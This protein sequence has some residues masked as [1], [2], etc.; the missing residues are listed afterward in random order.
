MGFTTNLFSECLTNLS[1]TNN[2]EHRKNAVMKITLSKR[3]LAVVLVIALILSA[4]N[5]YLIV[6]MQQG[7]KADDSTFNYVILQDG[8]LV[9]A[10]NQQSSLIDFSSD[11]AT[12][13][14]NQAINQGNHVYVKSGNY[15][16]NSDVEILNKNDARLI[17]DGANINANG[18]IIIIKGDNYTLSQYNEVSGFNIV[19]GTI[20]VENSFA[21]TISDMTFQNCKTAI[22]LTNSETW[23][24]GTK[25][26]NIHF[27][28]CAEAIAFRTPTGNATGS[29]ASTQ[30][31]RAFFNQEDN[32]VGINV[33]KD[34]E[35]SDSQI[36]NSRM[37]LGET[38]RTNQTGLFVDGSMFQTL[39]SSVV[40]ESFAD[41]PQNMYA[42]SVG[43]NA[44]PAPTIDEGVSFL[45]NW[46]ARVH[47]PYSKWLGGIG[48]VFRRT[49]NIPL[50]TDNEF[51]ETVNIQ[52]RPLT[53][54]SFKPKIDV[55]GIAAGE[56]VT[57]RVRLEF[58]DNVISQSVEKLFFNTTSTW[59]TD[60]DML[61][62]FPSQDVV[63][64]VLVDAKSSSASTSASVTVGI[65]GVAT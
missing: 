51:G 21:T 18:H 59:L 20:K 40:F 34:A 7:Y 25:I 30:I 5:T 4:V 22:E 36:S 53:I 14:I 33:E 56:T 47:N 16:L 44:N 11:S 49:E 15:T 6:T 55:Q 23:T 32:S 43:A 38:D 61:R 46:T 52:A 12:T 35:F 54:S 27:I 42:I 31:T 58:V 19:N 1:Q 17:S 29:Y 50:G 45:G 10:K 65:Y 63:W 57:V 3:F 2:G 9:K 37:W 28:D 62:L 24:E 13:V 41:S 26:D 60:D 64:A 39:L 8:G 48:T